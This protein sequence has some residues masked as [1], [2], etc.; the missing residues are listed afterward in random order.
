MAFI[1][2]EYVKFVRKIQLDPSVVVFHF[3]HVYG[4][5]ST[6]RV[7][8]NILMTETVRYLM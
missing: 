3:P 8:I 5:L 1:L 6:I 4:R 2:E 7:L